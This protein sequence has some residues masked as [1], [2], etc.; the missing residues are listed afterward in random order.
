M[1]YANPYRSFQTIILKEDMTMGG[2]ISIGII[3]N[4]GS[5][6]TIEAHT[7]FMPGAIINEAFAKTGDVSELR[8][9]LDKYEND[10]FGEGFGRTG[11]VPSDYGYV[12][13]DL[14]EGNFVAA[15]RFTNFETIIGAEIAQAEFF[16]RGGKAGA[17]GLARMITHLHEWNTFE[18]KMEYVEIEPFKDAS[19]LKANP[20][21]LY[22]EIGGPSRSFT[23]S[24]PSWN[25]SF[26]DYDIEGLEEVR[27]YLTGRGLLSP[28]DLGVW[29]AKIDEA[30][31]NKAEMD[32]LGFDDELPG[33]PI[34]AAPKVG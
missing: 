19:E 6:K 9:F 1:P 10:I 4:D 29:Q 15:Q 18:Q 20:E 5:L 33:A 11:N 25:T 3:E 14:R 31:R 7:K 26:H 24:Y 28:D 21:M 30:Y 12:L 23:V 32:A 34:V 22:Y 27:D 16:K 8:E 17:D 2:R 13:V